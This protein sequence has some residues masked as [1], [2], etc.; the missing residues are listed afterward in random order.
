MRSIF[1][2]GGSEVVRLFANFHTKLEIYTQIVCIYEV[3]GN[4]WNFFFFASKPNIAPIW[5]STVD[6]LSIVI[7]FPLF[8]SCTDI[9]INYL[10]S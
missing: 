5:H 3:Y 4:G 8:G 1:V 10:F 9:P 6:M 2:F 7:F